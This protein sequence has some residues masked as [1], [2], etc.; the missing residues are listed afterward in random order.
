MIH[1]SACG[2]K[3]SHEQSDCDPPPPTLSIGRKV[4][5]QH[6]SGAQGCLFIKT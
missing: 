4:A 2:P 3:E 6:V 1:W 5:P